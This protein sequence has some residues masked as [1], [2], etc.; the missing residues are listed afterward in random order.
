MR[1][2]IIILVILF[3]IML[4]VACSVPA[5][6]INATD[7][8]TTSANI[9]EPSATA[10][11][12]PSPTPTPAPQ[13]DTVLDAA[14][15]AY[16][17]GDWDAALSQFGQVLSSASDAEMRGLAQLG[18]VRIHIQTGRFLEAVQIA[19]VFLETFP[20]HSLTADGYFL[21]ARAGAE[22]GQ[23]AAAISD[24]DQYINIRTGILDGY[25]LELTGDMLR[26]SGD[27]VGAIA[28]YESALTVKDDLNLKIK[29]GSAYREAGDLQTALDLF[30]E[31][32]ML[33]SEASTLATLNLLQGLILEEL[34][35]QEAAFA[36]Y[37]ESIA[38]YPEAYDSYV[39]LV[40]LV[41]ADVAVDEYLRGYIDYQAGAYEPALAAFNRYLELTPTSAAYYYRGL[42]LQALGDIQGAR[43]DFQVVVEQ[44]A[45]EPF[46]VDAAGE[47]AYLEWAYLENP[48][49]A[50]ATYLG[51]VASAPEHGFA[52]DMLYAAARTA[53]R[54]GELWWA[55]ELWQ[56]V[57][58]E[59]PASPLTFDAAFQAGLCL[60]RV[61]D[62]AG[63]QALFSQALLYSGESEN[64]AKG[65][66]WLGKA[67]AAAG[68]VPGAHRA[69]DEAALSDPTGYY[70]ERALELIEGN[71]PF[72]S[73]GVFNFSTD[74]EAERM[75]AEA[76]LRA[77]FPITGLEPL[78]Q[79]DP[80]MATDARI[81]RGEEFWRLGLAYEAKQEFEAVRFDV[82]NDAEKTY[83]LMQRMLD[84][85]LYQ[86]AIYAARHILDMAGFDDAGTFTAP[87][88]FNHIRFGSYFG[89]LIFPESVANDLDGL[90]VLSVARQESLFEGF[91]TS[92]AA[93]RGV[94]QIIPSTGQDI[95]GRLGWPEGYDADDLFRPMVNIR[96]GAYYL[97]L[98]RD[99]FDA[100]FFAVLAAYNA[101][102][103][104]A[105]Q[106]YELAQ[107]D[108]DLFLEIVRFSETHNY[109]KTIYEVF[110]IYNDLYIPE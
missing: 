98:Q 108:P 7:T 2:K 23:V 46:W 54:A 5:G 11:Q 107:G 60:Y 78:N 81:L 10:T 61:G 86:P 58:A 39:G 17:N 25:V 70:A 67:L 56:R 48:A 27:T 106:W 92:Y 79:L 101:G 26:D 3:G 13:P 75:E 51:F 49:E 74:V 59:Y 83:R 32:K 109:I 69:W 66:L 38:N 90:F 100:D 95:Y 76:W 80:G 35:D 28:R 16:F 30:A 84:L 31:L 65:R 37:Q 36:L 33:V 20:G 18:L 93:A 91:I 14:E 102:P 21:R 15:R 88:Y 40:I 19:S 103:G 64:A 94:M 52:A 73:E 47:K 45:Q 6:L 72:Q 53:E 24:Y 89:E 9:S 8:M 12:V 4:S 77:S 62:F 57:V 105:G 87:V 99:L 97:G 43:A 96:Y 110:H 44:F 22:L 68:D 82:S 50:I 41:N 71:E 42:T 55:A 29:L 63:A 34:G 1:R 104:N 85:G